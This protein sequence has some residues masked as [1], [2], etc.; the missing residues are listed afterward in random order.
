[1]KQNKS[2]RNKILNI[3]IITVV[4]FIIITGI[5]LFKKYYNNHLNEKDISKFIED[6]YKIT[7]NVDKLNI[8]E[9]ISAMDLE[10]KGYKVLGIIAIP[11]IDLAYPIIDPLNDKNTAL[12]ISIIKFAGGNLN[13]KGNVTLAGHNYYDNT[14]FAKL[15]DLNISDKIE[16]MD[17][18]KAKVIYEIY[19][20][21]DVEP[22]DVSCIRT[23]DIN[24]KELTLITC[25]KGNSKRL[26]VRAKEV[27]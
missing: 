27:K 1:M 9:N 3:C 19:D 15:R 14:M 22:D 24:E 23:N 4:F 2:L 26:V 20:M 8:T 11:K 6:N 7:E 25:T 16:V 21:Q 18:K 12:N 17:N 13:E 5:M 10:Y